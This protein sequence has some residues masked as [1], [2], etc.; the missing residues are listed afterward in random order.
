MRLLD[1]F[2]DLDKEWYNFFG[3]LGDFH[4]ECGSYGENGNDFKAKNRSL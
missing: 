4:P 1:K 3:S 2:L